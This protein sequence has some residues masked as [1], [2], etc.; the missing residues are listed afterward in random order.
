MIVYLNDNI[1]PEAVALLKSSAE[2]VSDFDRIREIDGMVVR[3]T[4]VPRSIIEQAVN[5]K[6]IGRHGVGYDKVD[7]EAARE[8]HV[9]VL[10]APTANANSVAELI[11]ARFLEMSRDLYRGNVGLREGRFP[12]SSPPDM[13]GTEVTGKTLGLIGIGHIPQLVAAMMKAAFHVHVIGYDP[14]VSAEEFRR[15]GIVKYDRLEQML[16]AADLV[17]ISVHRT[18]AT[19]NMINASTFDHFRPGAIFVNTSRGG[20]VDEDALYDALTAK[21]L[22]AAAFDVFAKEPCPPDSKL[23]T[24]EN[25][26]ATPHIGGNTEE[27]LYNT[28]MTIVKN[29]LNVLH[30]LPAEGIVV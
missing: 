2:V 12:K 8:H 20:I 23:L 13:V 15:R 30:G 17:S 22:R 19:Q 11:V 5:L 25:F 18:A 28:G 26:S 4:P 16:E 6:V 24:L 21:K 9:R 14:Y 27:A 3:A 7:I 29:V 10:N 1:H